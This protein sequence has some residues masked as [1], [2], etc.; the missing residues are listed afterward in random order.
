MAERDVASQTP[1]LDA[2]IEADGEVA[3]VETAEAIRRRRGRVVAHVRR[4][5]PAPG[6]PEAWTSRVSVRERV[7]LGDAASQ[8]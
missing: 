8:A 5:G 1:L 3:I 4:P 6:T 7:V 2:W